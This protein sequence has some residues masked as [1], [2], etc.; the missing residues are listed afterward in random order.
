MG[1]V[2]IL[3]KQITDYP[4]SILEPAR[5]SEEELG[6]M[7]SDLKL[8]MGFIKYF[9]DK[10]ALDSYMKKQEGFHTILKESVVLLKE[11]CSLNLDVEEGE[12]VT[13]MC[14]AIQD[15]QDEARIIGR[16]EGRERL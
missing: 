5:L 12:D 9:A 2:D 10:E 15:M 7:Q 8:V 11:V 13:D 3:S 1:K 4:L 16:E 14:K 6:R